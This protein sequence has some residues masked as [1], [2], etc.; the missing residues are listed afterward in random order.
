MMRPTR[1]QIGPHPYTVRFADD[2]TAVKQAM[3]PE[4]HVSEG[5]LGFASH[6]KNQIVVGTMLAPSQQ[7]DTLLHEVLHS[8]L[9]QIAM[10]NERLV[11]RLAPTLLDFMRRNPRA[12]DFLTEKP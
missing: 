10:D 12:V 6:Q 11:W 8:L 1:L 4:E 2:P 7:R 9:V 3:H 5:L